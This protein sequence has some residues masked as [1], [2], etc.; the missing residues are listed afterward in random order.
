MKDA[1]LVGFATTCGLVIII[2][3]LSHGRQPTKPVMHDHH[4]GAVAAAGAAATTRGCNSPAK[5]RDPWSAE[6]AALIVEGFPRTGTWVLI[7]D[8]TMESFYEGLAEA[9]ACHVTNSEKGRRVWSM[10]IGNATVRLYPTWG[11]SVPKIAAV[12]D[13]D[14]LVIGFGLHALHL[15]PVRRCG[16]PR[17]GVNMDCRRDYGDAVRDSLA[18]LHR[19]APDALKFWRTT[20]AI[21]E[22]Q[23]QGGYKAAIDQW[24][25]NTTALEI[26]CQAN[27][28]CTGT[29]AD[30]LFDR[31]GTS[32]Q[33][34]VALDVLA[35]NNVS[36][37][38][39]H[40]LDAFAYTDN[41]CEY[42]PPRDGRHY[43]RLE[44]LLLLDLL[45]H[46]NDETRNRSS[47]LL[48]GSSL[49]SW[50]AKAAPVLADVV[51]N[52]S[53]SYQQ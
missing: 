51:R 25:T 20:N 48:G 3:G 18:V 42:T 39:A 8:S 28:T 52:M 1:R 23:F 22:G 38:G 47:P 45:L 43:A 24:H 40:L 31:R 27:D 30:R 34:D 13:A 12:A 17:F 46:I 44:P 5:S 7:G 6:V 36:S 37:D 4:L 16:D 50:Y 10:R 2:F 32:I 15:Y 11:C 35:S 21:C 26:Q 29:C 41:R 9:A 49:A 53:S 33:R 14:V 19:A